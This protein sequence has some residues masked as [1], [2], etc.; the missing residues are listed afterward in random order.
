MGVISN[1]FFESGTAGWQPVNNAGAVSIGAVTNDGTARVGT[2]Y[3]QV[4]TS[5]QGGSVAIDIPQSNYVQPTSLYALAWLRAPQGQ[6]D[7]TLAMWEIAHSPYAIVVNMNRNFT[8]YGNEWF[9]IENGLDSLPLPGGSSEVS[10]RLEFY[11]NTI[12]QPLDI[13]SVMWWS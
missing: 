10:Y 12:N 11:I 2:S 13:D 5:Q 7:V 4:S 6:V 1:S 9:M 8:A 3:L